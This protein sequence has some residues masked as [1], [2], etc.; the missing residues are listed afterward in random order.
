VDEKLAAII[1]ALDDYPP[2]GEDRSFIDVFVLGSIT[3]SN[4]HDVLKIMSQRPELNRAF[5]KMIN[6]A[7]QSEEG[8]RSIFWIGSDMSDEQQ[9]RNRSRLRSAV[10]IV[11]SALGSN[12][13]HRNALFRGKL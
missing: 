12:Q 7:P 11:R 13:V 8:W 10:E 4:V 2:S 6:G 1:K 3:E 5:W 9:N